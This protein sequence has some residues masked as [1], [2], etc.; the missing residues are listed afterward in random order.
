MVGHR[1]KGSIRSGLSEDVREVRIITSET[2][3][4]A[5]DELKEDFSRKMWVI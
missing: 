1:R 3:V 5:N 4:Y 2:L